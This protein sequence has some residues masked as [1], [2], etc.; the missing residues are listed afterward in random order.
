M[1]DHAHIFVIKEKKDIKAALI[2]LT[3][4]QGFELVTLT[5]EQ[6]V[7]LN[8]I[9]HPP[10]S[11]LWFN[12]PDTPWKMY[13]VGEKADLAYVVPLHH[14]A[15]ID[16]DFH[17][18]AVALS[19]ELNTTLFYLWEEHATDGFG[20]YQNGV[21]EKNIAED[22]HGPGTE[23]D[24]KKV[25]YSPDLLKKTLEQEKLTDIEKHFEQV[26]AGILFFLKKGHSQDLDRMIKHAEEQ[27]RKNTISF[28]IK[29][30][31]FLV[32]IIL[33]IRSCS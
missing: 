13:R 7:W 28:F 1:F 23:I 16:S 33:L 3:E 15:F 5:A 6:S 24:G 14:E 2:K 19:R 20:K 25:A 17:D 29:F 26:Q 21:R 11:W 22:T 32:I 9:H 18:E 8:K 12:L 30:A 31:V 4:L 27:W 10:D